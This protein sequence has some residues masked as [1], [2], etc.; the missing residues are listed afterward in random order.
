MSNYEITKAAAND[1]RIIARYIVASKGEAKL[2]AF[3]K[4]LDKTMNKM[5]EDNNSWR[6]TTLFDYTINIDHCHEFFILGI[7]RENKP[8]L[9][10]AIL[11]EQT[12]HIKRL[13]KNMNFFNRLPTPREMAE[14]ARGTKITRADYNTLTYDEG[15]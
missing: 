8:L 15:N 7:F 1:W 13:A 12:E 2:R 3:Y 10:F 4:N 9:V 6:Y 5:A 14:E 11:H